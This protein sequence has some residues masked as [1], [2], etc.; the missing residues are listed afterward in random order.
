MG[1]HGDRLQELYIDGQQRSFFNEELQTDYTVQH[2]QP[3]NSMRKTGELIEG[4]VIPPVNYERGKKYPAIL[5]I[6]GGPHVAFGPTFFHEMQVWANCGYFVFYCNP[7]GSDGYGNAF[8][9]MRGIYGTKDYEDLMSFTDTVLSEYPDID[10]NRIGVTGGSYGGYMTNW[11]VG[12][13]NRSACAAAQRS[14]SDWAISEWISDC[15]F[16]R[17][18]A[19]MGTTALENMEKVMWH[20]PIRYVDNVKTPILFVHS[21][22]DYR[23]HHTQAIA[24]FT[25]LRQRGI[26]S[27]LCIFKGENHEL[28]R[29]GKPENRIARM[30]EILN[31]MDRFLKTSPSQQKA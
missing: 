25:L 3:L 23:C 28:S 12:H 19:K 13:T 31:W 18:A 5:N 2:P 6:H 20:S 11:I 22:E 17:N 16:Q 9:D 21:Y 7:Q 14:I 30:Q 24:M 8:G 26:E 1:M 4:W 10:S 29:S 27:R 15:G